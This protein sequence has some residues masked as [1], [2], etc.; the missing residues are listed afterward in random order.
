MAVRDTS[1]EKQSAA[2]GA[3]GRAPG[4]VSPSRAKRKS[5]AARAKAPSRTRS[6]ALGRLAEYRRKRDPARTT[7]PFEA[8]DGDGFFVVQKHAATRLHYDFRLAMDGVLVSWAVP[9]GPSYDTRQKRLAVHVEDHPLSYRDFEGVIPEGEYGAGSVIVWDAGPYRLREG[10]VAAGSLKLDLFGKKLRGGWAL[11]RMKPREGRKDEW[12]LLKERDEHVDPERDVTAEEPQSVLSGLTIEEIGERK[13]VRQWNSGLM[14]TI[15]GLPTA[16][17]AREGRLPKHP[18][19]MKAKLVAAPPAGKGW[20]FEIKLDGVRALAIRESGKVRL[21][22]RNAKEV[23]FRY[24]EVLAGLEAVRGGDFVLDGEIVAFD[25]DGRSRFELL[26]GRI[27]LTGRDRIAEA[28]RQTPAFYYAFDVL[29]AEGHRLEEVP[30]AERKQVLARLLQSAPEPV[31]YSDHVEGQG[32]A[33]FDLACGRGLEGVIGKRADAPYRGT[34]SGDWVKVKCLGQQEFVIG[35]FTPPQGG[36]THLGALLLG[37][38]AGDRLEYV[39]KVGTGFTE[40]TLAD[41]RRRL[42]KLERAT[43]PFADL[44]R[45]RG[46]RW[47]STELVAEV[48][49]TE[50]TSDGRLRHPAFLG[51]REDKDPRAC[52]RD[53]PAASASARDGKGSPARARTA[54]KGED[55]RSRGEDGGSPRPSSTAHRKGSGGAGSRAAQPATVE[56]TNPDKIFYPESGITKGNVAAYYAGVADVILPYLEDRPLTL[57]RFPNGI[58]GQ[59]FFQK[60]QPDWLP[61]WILTVTVRS[62]DAGR[63][64]DYLLCNDAATLAYVANLGTIDLHPWASRVGALEKPDYVVW[65]LDPPEAGFPKAADVAPRVREVLERA[66]LVPFLKTSG[67]KGL[68]L[69]VPLAPENDHD[70]VRDFAELVAR[71][72]VEANPR[73]TTLERAKKGRDGK[74]YVDFLQNGRGK[75]VVA[76]YSLRAKEPATVSMPITWKEFDEGVAPGDFTL[77]TVPKLL[78]RRADAW[79]GFWDKPRSL[80]AALEVLSSGKT[81]AVAKSAARKSPA[82]TRRRKVR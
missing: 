60:D 5:Q 32:A 12:L 51:L 38:Y 45:E 50:W 22:T 49:F 67:G 29:F 21:V 37:V 48:R 9:K 46:V 69:Y 16:A 36:R 80:A 40:E 25:A 15:E 63:D 76:P 6:V 74:V 62:Q 79:R 28:A 19:F 57:V 65:D 82:R 4:A 10:S 81:A 66:G 53:L 14:K 44:P 13:G 75:T 1:R 43:S 56:I 27:H 41:L 54:R 26:Q 2:S 72:V 68:H 33:F 30:L 78:S 42:K 8:G 7:E 59:S 64:V 52:V 20:L 31:R 73:T 23:A 70:Q 55:S 11:V 61:K 35:G 18:E 17:A 71:M 34:R 3:G 24:P 58:A 47:V 39:G 77:R